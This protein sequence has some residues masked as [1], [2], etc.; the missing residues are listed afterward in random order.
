VD[1]GNELD[2]NSAKEDEVKKK[3]T[4]LERG[5]LES[6]MFDRNLERRLTRSQSFLVNY[7]LM[8]QVMKMDEPQNYA[9]ASRKKEWNEAM[10]A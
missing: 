3:P 5:Y 10:E 8:A 1:I 6:N 9:E 7:A 4:W 2:S